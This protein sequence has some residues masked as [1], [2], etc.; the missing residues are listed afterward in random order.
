MGETL[1][2]P[3]WGSEFELKQIVYMNYVNGVVYCVCVH[4]KHMV[5][6]KHLCA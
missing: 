6:D 3:P 1:G 4:H 2:M 5:I